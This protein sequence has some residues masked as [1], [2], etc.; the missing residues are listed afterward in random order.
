MII[1][2]CDHEVTLENELNISVKDYDREGERAIRYMVVCYACK[3][4]MTN[5]GKILETEEACH[6]WL[7]GN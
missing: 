7:R 3:E 1:A 6:E 5:L 4:I 2:S